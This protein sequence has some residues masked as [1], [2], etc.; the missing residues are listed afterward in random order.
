[1]T[2]MYLIQA[3]ILSLVIDYIE[4]TL[5]LK[6]NVLAKGYYLGTWGCCQP[7][8]NHLHNNDVYFAIAMD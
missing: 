6:C 2:T 8:T 3:Q 5:S 7:S 1:M 4:I